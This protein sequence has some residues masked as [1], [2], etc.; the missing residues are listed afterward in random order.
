MSRSRV[1]ELLSQ[2]YEVR[3]LAVF[4]SMARGDDHEASDVD[5]LVTFEGDRCPVV[6]RGGSPISP[7][8][9]RKFLDGLRRCRGKT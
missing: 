4:G 8:P 1:L 6:F 9:L 5:V 3:S 2:R 7:R